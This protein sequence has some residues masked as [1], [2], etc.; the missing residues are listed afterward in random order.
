MTCPGSR[1]G[2]SW[3]NPVYSIASWQMQH[4]LGPGDGARVCAKFYSGARGGADQQD[5]LLSLLNYA[6]PYVHASAR[7]VHR[8]SSS[9]LG[10]IEMMHC[11]LVAPIER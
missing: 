11:D 3:G 9:T 8:C 5:I 6:V 7:I 10:A 2:A 4:R 1:N